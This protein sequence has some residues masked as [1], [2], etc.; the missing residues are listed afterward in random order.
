MMY[1]VSSHIRYERHCPHQD[2]GIETGYSGFI[3]G[4]SLLRRPVGAVMLVL[5]LTLFGCAGGQDKGEE[6]TMRACRVC[7][8][9]DR[10]CES[11]GK[12]DEKG[13]DEVVGRM[14]A[15]GASLTTEERTLVT[16]WLASR[17]RGEKPP[18][19]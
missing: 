1:C 7:H 2:D 11:L 5:S 6:V 10:L 13:W 18:C 4:L 19:P 9:A 3:G 16:R 14:V 15:S 17:K 12:L 8:G